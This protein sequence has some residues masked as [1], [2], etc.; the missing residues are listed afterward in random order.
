MNR[1][2]LM[3][4]TDISLKYNYKICRVCISGRR[5]VCLEKCVFAPE[6][7]AFA[8]KMSKKDIVFPP[9]DKRQCFMGRVKY[10]NC[11]VSLVVKKN[12]FCLGMKLAFVE[13]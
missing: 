12:T 2:I 8:R 10:K 4:H 3:R 6:K 7:C 9:S 11:L 1:D 13:F 5:G